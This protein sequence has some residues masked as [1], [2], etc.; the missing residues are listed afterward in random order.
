[1]SEIIPK[2]KLG[3]FQRWQINS[4]DPPKPELPQS[5]PPPPAP[6]ETS[7]EEVP[8]FTLPT[9]EDIERLHEESR[10][11]G[12]QAGYEEGRQAAEETCR[13]AATNEIERLATL[14]DGLQSALDE[15]D[16]NVAEQLLALATEIASQMISGTIAVK[17]DILLPIIREAIAALPLQHGHLTL[18]LNPADATLVRAQLGE[19]LAQSGAQI[20]DDSEISPGGCLVRAGTSEV[21]ATIETRWKRVLEAIGSEPKAWLS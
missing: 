13:A 17:E 14:V 10:A 18:R 15:L 1:M 19:Q 6:V 12:Y 3:G 21:D 20:I 2:E 4:F 16:Q 11:A 9:A 5:A 7:E 8:A